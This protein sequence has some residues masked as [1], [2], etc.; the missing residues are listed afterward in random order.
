MKSTIARCT[1]HVLPKCKQNYELRAQFCSTRSACS[2]LP[3]ALGHFAFSPF[4]RFVFVLKA[5]DPSKL[6][7]ISRRGSRKY[8][9]II[10]GD[11]EDLAKPPPGATL[12]VGEAEVE[13]N[14]I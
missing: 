14:L 7:S 8:T 2:A 12:R 11:E 4:L 5:R 10:R 13:P 1:C 3:F 9:V 6:N